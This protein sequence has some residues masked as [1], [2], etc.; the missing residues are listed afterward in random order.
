MTYVLVLCILLVP[1]IGFVTERR[2]WNGGKC[3]CGGRWKWFDTDSQG[4]RGYQCTK[5]KR[6]TWISYPGI[7]PVKGRKRS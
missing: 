4:G 5:C 6:Y 7:D 3:K 2:T 1:V